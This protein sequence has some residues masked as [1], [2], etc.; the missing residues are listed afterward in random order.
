[1]SLKNKPISHLFSIV[2][3][4]AIWLFCFVPYIF[5]QFFARRTMQ[6]AS[7]LA[8]TTLLSLV[9]LIAVMFSFFS[10]L[11]VFKDLSEI[12]QEF[13]FSNFVPS[14]GQTIR[15]YLINFSI[16]AS[17]LTT[18]GIILLVVIAL[19][20]MSTIN[21]ALDNI[22][23]ITKRRSLIGRFLVYWAILTLGP[24]LIG[25]GFY[26]TSYLLALP[27][28]ESVDSAVMIKSRLLALMPFFTT[29]IAFTLL[30]ILVP[31][32]NVNTRHAIAGGVTA[33]ILFEL[34]KYTFGLY[35]KAVP[36]YQVIYGAMA[37]IPMFLIWI[38][39]SWVIVLLGAQISYSLSVFRM[40]DIGKHHSETRWG[41]LDAYQII[42]E[43]WLA[44]KQGTG[45]SVMQ[46]KKSGVRIAHTSMNEIFDLLIKANWINRNTIGQYY[47]IRDLGEL[48]LL[49][50]YKILPCKLPNN[51][52][53]PAN[54]WQKSLKGVLAD[55]DASLAVA[56]AIP[57]NKA[58]KYA[59]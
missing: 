38:Y 51:M 49:D 1:M 31:N 19:M 59:G 37:V 52:D 47:L 45:R 29:S 48:T 5:Q 17:Q 44:Q 35:V 23:Y 46:L 36:T 55:S 34:A 11:P 10:N 58:L 41:F 30:Y 50:L 27:L 26:S 39:V 18:T 56:L 20:L 7:S 22:W 57:V 3:S 9:P 21:S 16:K 4:G 54:K 24:V 12:I 28:I 14:F 15:D 2:K 43:L 42:G 53:R 8:Y 25:V 6:S 33:A 40:E 13:V 32:T